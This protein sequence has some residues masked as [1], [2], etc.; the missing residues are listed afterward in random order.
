MI[1]E[2][3]DKYI[4]ESLDKDFINSYIKSK[5]SNLD[6]INIPNCNNT[7]IGLNDS[8]WDEFKQQRLT[9]GYDDSEMWNLCNTIAKFIYPRLVTFKENGSSFPCQ[10]SESK[11]N[12]YLDTMIFAFKCFSKVDAIDLNEKDRKK[13]FKGLGLFS[14]YFLDLWS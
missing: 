7:Q 11:W 3:P 5:V 14:K 9:R 8:R 12:K 10:L 6:P 4:I 1:I 13:A 2:V